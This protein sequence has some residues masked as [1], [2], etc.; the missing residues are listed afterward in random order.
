MIHKVLELIKQ[1]ENSAIEFMNQDVSPDSMANEFVAFSNSLGGN[2]LIGVEDDGS[3]S[4][5]EKKSRK[6]EE[7]VQNIAR[8]SV[9]PPI[10][11]LEVTYVTIDGRDVVNIDI[12]KGRHKPYQTNKN[13]YLV[14]AGSTNR[15]AS[16]AEMLR[17][18]QQSGMFH[19]DLTAIPKSRMKDLDF[20][21]IQKY[22][23]QYDIDFGNDDHQQQLLINTDILTEQGEMTVAGNLIFGIN[24]QKWMPNASIS[25]AHFHG[26]QLTAELIDKK[27]VE[28]TLDAQ[29]EQLMTIIQN[30]RLHGSDIAGLKTVDI[31]TSYPDKVFRELIVNACIH[32]N[33][34]IHGSRAR[35]FMFSDRIEFISPGRLPNSVTISKM[36]SGVSFSSN[37]VILKF[38]ENLRYVDKLDRGVPLVKQASIKLGKIL[39]LE[40]IGEEFKVT[41]GL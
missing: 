1:G 38:M 15:V 7:W 5:I 29:V 21:R 33:Y 23:E 10:A 22:F 25:F 6:W 28:G 24:P 32:R 4:G 14:R 36:I 35:V 41:L 13:Q 9:N 2:L 31:T 19:F 8:D 26:V 11:D 27:T 18:F 34:A 40:E 12:P 20:N 17:L 16:N 37:P 39:L 3:I 30:N